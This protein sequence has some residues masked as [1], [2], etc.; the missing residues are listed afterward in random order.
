MSFLARGAARR[1]LDKY[2]LVIHLRVVSPPVKVPEIVTGAFWFPF[3]DFA[4]APRSLR[5]SRSGPT[6]LD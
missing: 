4:L 3:M 6:G 1:R 5:E 2:W